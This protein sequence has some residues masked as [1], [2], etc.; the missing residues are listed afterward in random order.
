MRFSEVGKRWILLFEHVQATKC[1][2]FQ[3]SKLQNATVEQTNQITHLTQEI[4][5]LQSKGR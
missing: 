2:I 4:S 3:V 5:A 1:R